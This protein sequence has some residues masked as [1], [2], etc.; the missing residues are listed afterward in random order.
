MV[1]IKKPVIV[2]V[3][4]EVVFNKKVTKDKNF[5]LEQFQ[6]NLIG[7]PYGVPQ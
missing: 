3:N 6:R 7:C 2:N 5:I 1:N 4:G